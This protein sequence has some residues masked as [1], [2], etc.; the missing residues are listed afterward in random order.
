MTNRRLRTGSI[1]SI[2]GF[3]VGKDKT[4]GFVGVQLPG[5]RWVLWFQ[6]EV[7]K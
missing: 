5:C 1:V 6:R 3:I 4:S 7:L 2:R